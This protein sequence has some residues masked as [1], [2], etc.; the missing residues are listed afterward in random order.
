M[1]QCD[2]DDCTATFT[3]TGPEAIEAG[4]RAINHN[5][6]WLCR[7]CNDVET[8][9]GFRPGTTEGDDESYELQRYWDQQEAEACRGD[10][11]R[12]DR[13]DDQI[14]REHEEGKP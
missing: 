7:E 8:E 12:D 6:T 9:Y 11:L 14:Q 10:A 5:G 13:K 2:G 4:W 3:G 1:I